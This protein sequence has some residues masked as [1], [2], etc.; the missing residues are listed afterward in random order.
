M[1]TEGKFWLPLWM[2]IGTILVTLISLGIYASYLSD[3]RDLALADK[4]LQKY[5]VE[6]C[7]RTSVFTEWHEA[8]WKEK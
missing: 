4:G 5:K 6:R 2:V 8:G 3:Q 1:N 7:T